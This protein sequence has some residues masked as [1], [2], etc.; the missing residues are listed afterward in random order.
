MRCLLDLACRLRSWQYEIAGI[1]GL[2]A[3]VNIFTSVATTKDLPL[4]LS[5][6]AS[7]AWLALGV[8]S[9][10]LAGQ[11][12]SRETSEARATD[13]EILPGE[14]NKRLRVRLKDNTC[15]GV[16]VCGTVASLLAAIVLTTM[17]IVTRG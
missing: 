13:G 10:W 8:Q 6:T 12:R 16:V 9:L 3:A 2:S 1:I 11:F 5:V 17:L 14:L 7:V 4:L 15:V